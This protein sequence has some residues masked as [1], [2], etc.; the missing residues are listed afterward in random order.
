MLMSWDV[1]GHW[2]ASL[3]TQS[4]RDVFCHRVEAM[5]T[6][7]VGLSILVHHCVFIPAANSKSCSL[8]KPF[9]HCRRRSPHQEQETRRSM[10]LPSSLHIYIRV[11]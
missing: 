2:L 5:P 10:S 4:S 6:M 11:L 1:L 7:I 3:E 8:R 9:V